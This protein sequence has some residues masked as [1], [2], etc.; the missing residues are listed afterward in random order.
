MR[1][2]LSSL[3]DHTLSS[4]HRGLSSLIL[5]CSTLLLRSPS[6]K[7]GQNLILNMNDKGFTVVAYNR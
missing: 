5:C 6:S 7:Q 1:S 3:A 4:S 2:S